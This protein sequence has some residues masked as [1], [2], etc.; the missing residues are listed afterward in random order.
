MFPLDYY[1]F[2]RVDADITQM[3]TVGPQIPEEILPYMT[4]EQLWE[5][6]LRYPNKVWSPEVSLLSSA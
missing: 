3:V 5:T 6:C 2:E 4:T 1:A